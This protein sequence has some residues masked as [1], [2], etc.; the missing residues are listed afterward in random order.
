V[1]GDV[2]SLFWTQTAE[3]DCRFTAV[4]WARL[5]EEMD[6]DLPTDNSAASVAIVKEWMRANR[7]LC[8]EVLMTLEHRSSAACL[9]SEYSLD[10]ATVTAS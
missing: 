7:Q 10:R 1:T 4:E 9:D 3:W 2:V 6:S 8:E 5:V